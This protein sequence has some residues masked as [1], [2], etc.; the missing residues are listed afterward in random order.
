MTFNPVVIASLRRALNSIRRRVSQT[1]VKTE[2]YGIYRVVDPVHTTNVYTSFYN[3]VFSGSRSLIQLVLNALVNMSTNSGNPFSLP[4]KVR[5][6]TCLDRS[7]FTVVVSVPGIK[8]PMSAVAPVSHRFKKCLL[9]VPKVKPIAE[10]DEIDENKLTHKLVLFDPNKLDS[11]GDFNQNNKEFFSVNGVCLE[12]FQHYSLTLSYENWTYDE[13][14]DAVL[15]KD[16][17]SV[18]GFSTV[19]HIAHLNLRDHLLDYKHL[20]GI[21]ITN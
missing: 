5:G 7:A 6:M 16:A 4:E 13:I 14:L 8:V 9:K 1:L 20:I 19:G 3:K 15:P 21:S 17:D 18:G 11:A 2:E 10:L 12:S